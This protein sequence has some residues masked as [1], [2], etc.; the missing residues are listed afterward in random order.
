M[1]KQVG[2]YEV[3]NINKANILTI[4]VNPKEHLK[5]YKD[6]SVNKKLKGVNR[7]TPGMDFEAYSARISTL[8]EFCQHNK[9]KKT[10][11]KDFKL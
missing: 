2:L 11:K 5:K 1:K 6:Y 3:E 10:D 4:A 8:H 9:S 7:N